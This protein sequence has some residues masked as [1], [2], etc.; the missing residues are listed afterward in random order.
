[1]LLLAAGPLLAQS[2][3]LGKADRMFERFEFF[4][5]AKLYEK[6]L[7]KQDDPQAQ[8]RL[9]ECYRLTNKFDLA[10]KWYGQAVGER[11]VEPIF[12]F[13]YGQMLLS[14]GR[15][16]EAAY[17]FREYAT[18]QPN[19]GR[20][21]RFEK[22]CEELAGLYQD[23][24]RYTVEALGINSA[25]AEFGPAFYNDELVFLSSRPDGR[26]GAKVHD[27]SGEPFL[28]YYRTAQ[29]DDG[30]RE[31]SPFGGSSLNSEFH[32]GPLVFSPDGQR[33]FFTRNIDVADA[34][35]EQSVRTVR[36]QIYTAERQSD[37]RWTKIRPLDFNSEDYSTASPALSQDG[38]LMVF[39][40]TR[41]GGF[42]G[43][44]LYWT[45]WENEA[46]TRPVNLGSGINTEG[47]EVFPFLH[48]DGTLYFS[49][50]G[51][52]GL[53]GLDIFGAEPEGGEGRDALVS[54]EAVSSEPLDSN[55]QNL[56]TWLPARNLGWALNS[57]W[58][59]FGLV[60]DAERENGY[61][62]SN[63]EG[64]QGGDDLYFM[65]HNWV[66]VAGI[67]VDSLT[68]EPL[69]Y[70][71]VHVTGGPGDKRLRANDVGAFA[72]D[73]PRAA[74]LAFEGHAD[75]YAKGIAS[76]KTPAAGKPNHVRVAL[77]PEGIPVRLRV[78][79]AKSGRVLPN[80]N[81][82]LRNGCSEEKS[83]MVADANGEISLIWSRSCDYDWS[84]SNEGYADGFLPV[85]HADLIGLTEASFTLLLSP[86]EKGLTVELRNI[87]YDYNEAFI[88]EDA[89][90]DLITLA[91]LMKANPALTI[92]LGSH[93]D[94]RG[95]DKYN[96][97][98]SQQRA[99]AAIAYLSDLGIDAGR[100]TARGYGESKLKNACG[101]GVQCDDDEHQIN[102]R[103][104]FKV[105]GLD[106]PL[107]SDD[108]ES[109]PVNTGKR[110][111]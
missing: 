16:E 100:M 43:A 103:T 96:Q 107:E 20:G 99:E 41:P 97:N 22:A 15:C 71:S 106:Y 47:D 9:A 14:A 69:P 49:S 105:T 38:L 80:A 72:L 78:V 5:A 6:A 2:G 26:G 12:K 89:V 19:D 83:N 8:L 27:W 35:K 46:W 32:E 77:Q 109:I 24:G 7:A 110:A 93:T 63:R 61:F 104:E 39:S 92:E 42:G 86:L 111:R 94:A 13:R 33:V 58:D 84:A 65:R 54:A 74:A 85:S 64:G 18:L 108:K 30:F 23:N 70:A 55:R 57:R 60:W 90:S 73:L 29:T 44:D 21:A 98:L 62:A 101:N 102:R 91:E 11:G 68:G 37:K 3:K 48:H 79:D 95:S 56:G 66:R 17:W 34:T 25:Y 31:A 59:D 28:N 88:R 51:H 87:Y 52:A 76:L 67:V 1:M 45:R 10:A 40:S 81:V 82:R 53:G 75:G 50:D 4:E 36:L